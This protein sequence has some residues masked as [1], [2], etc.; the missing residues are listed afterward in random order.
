MSELAPSRPTV[1]LWWGSV[2]SA[3]PHLAELIGLLDDDER[4][5]AERFRPEAAR[6]RF[7]AAHAM[8][9]NL[10]AARTGAPPQRLRFAAIS[11]G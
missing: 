1:E 10:L 5:R 11:Q 2:A 4:R 7:V 8:L 9:R 3:L 6:Q